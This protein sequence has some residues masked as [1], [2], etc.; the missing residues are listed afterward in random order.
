MLKPFEVG[1]RSRAAREGGWQGRRRNYSCRQ[2]G[3]KFQ[4]DTRAPLPEKERLC[5]KCQEAAKIRS[6]EA[7]LSKL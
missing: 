1:S 7:S 2:C 5:P 3:E 6:G 4:V